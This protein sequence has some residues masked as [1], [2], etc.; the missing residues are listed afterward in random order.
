MDKTFLAGLVIGVGALG[1][2]AGI[3]SYNHTSAKA[4]SD[5]GE[6]VVEA[7]QESA[8][9]SDPVFAEVTSVEP[10]KETYYTERE[11]CRDE[12]VQA[13]APVQDE[14]K[15]AGT[16]IGAIIG[17]V[18]GNQVGGGSGKKLATVAGAVAGA[19]AGRKVQEDMQQQSVESRVET[20]CDNVKEPLQR[21]TGYQVSYRI[22]EE[23]G[24]LVMASKP[25]DTLPVKDGKIVT[26]SVPPAP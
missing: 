12:M 22:G 13:Q 15:V 19:Y 2:A 18:L 6:A 20:Y 4:S 7:R 3:G 14:Q 16:A 5:G 24:S 25:G 23:T 8:S 11:V 26:E 21:I 10:I 17:G 1:T 9:P